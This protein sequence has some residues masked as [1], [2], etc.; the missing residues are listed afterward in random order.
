MY[1][2]KNPINRALEGL[3]QSASTYASMDQN[4]PAQQDPG[5]TIGGA[6]QSGISGART[7]YN[8]LDMLGTVPAAVGA[9]EVVAPTAMQAANAALL[10]PG[11]GTAS[12]SLF[13]PPQ[14]GRAHV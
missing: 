11:A 14:I 3:E 9:T 4:I 12:P 6:L 10:A 2:V 5:P 1:E 7:G 8:A 13:P